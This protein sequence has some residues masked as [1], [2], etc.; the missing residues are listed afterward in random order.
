MLM[1][2]QLRAAQVAAGLETSMTDELDALLVEADQVDGSQAAE[3]EP[4]QD[5]RPA[6]KGTA[7]EY[8]PD[9]EIIGALKVVLMMA[10]NGLASYYGSD[11]WNL[12]DNQANAIAVPLDVVLTKYL[13]SGY[14]LPPEVTLLMAIGAVFV[15]KIQQQMAL[16]NGKESESAES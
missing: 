12:D 15:P 2:R 16:D 14:N 5:Q 1:L 6:V 7:P 9:A 4:N 8:Q 3:S 13:G 11:H 10:G